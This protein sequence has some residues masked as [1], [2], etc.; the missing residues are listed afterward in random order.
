MISW[1]GFFAGLILLG[2]TA[3][4]VVKTFMV[5]RATRSGVNRVV[6]V[7]VFRTFGLLTA[8]IDDL[9]RR[10]R[11]HALSAPAFLLCLLL[12][13]L[14]SVFAGFALLLW[15]SA[16]SFPLA[17]RES[18]SSLF[19]LGFAPPGSSG[20][21]AIVFAAAA[22]GLAVLA[23]LI[24]Y[25]PLLYTAFN[26]RETQV[27][28]LEALAGSPPWGPELLARQ[29]LIEN[30]ATL[31]GLYARWTE[32]AADISES[33]VNYRT[34]VYF[35]S[36]DPSTSW[37]LSLLAVLDGAALHLALNP[38]SAPHEARPLLRVGY[39]TLRRLAINLRLPVNDDPSPDD[40][41]ELTRA[42][43]DEAV[44][45][46]HDAGWRTERS[47]DDAWPDFHGWRVNYEAAAYQ[48]ALH[49]DLPPAMWS[50]PRRPGRPPAAPPR[51]PTDRRPGRV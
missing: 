42:D 41:I 3:A 40:P 27:T 16:G 6:F 25:L 24:A 39:S 31:T 50:G 2:F 34:L 9:D 36:P 18:G 7:F 35:R 10:E 11:V 32:W 38:S 45:W 5:P 13:W 33:H 1:L 30:S 47:A 15:P 14:A 49:L 26:R 23:L 43:F 19:T 17:M 28:M 51:R 37:L 4:S 48:L 29:A 8:R 46:L 12:A 21:S 20:A 22:S 44:R